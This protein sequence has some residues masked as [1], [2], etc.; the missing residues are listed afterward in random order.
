M[1]RYTQCTITPLR[2]AAAAAA[3]VTHARQRTFSLSQPAHPFALQQTC[4]WAGTTAT[5]RPLIYPVA[6]TYGMRPAPHRCRSPALQGW[7][8]VMLYVPQGMDRG[9]DGAAA[10]AAAAAARRRR[11]RRRGDDRAAASI[12]APHL[13]II[14]P[15]PAAAIDHG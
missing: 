5:R 1:E 14:G 11:R 3:A 15:R 10:R 6:L 12:A 8:C 9:G 13:C 7:T 2:V 4:R